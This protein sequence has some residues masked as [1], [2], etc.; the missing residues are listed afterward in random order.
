MKKDI[1]KS[2]AN[3]FK[4]SPMDTDIITVNHY[5][6][7]GVCVR[8]M[9]V[10]AGALVI[11]ASHKTKHLTTL[12]KGSM[13]IRLGNESKLVEAP[14][15]FESL[16]GSRKVGLAYT[17]CVVHNVF[18]TNSKD[19]EEIERQFTTMH[20]DKYELMLN[21]LGLSSSEVDKLSR[22]KST[23]TPMGQFVV[24]PSSIQGQGL[25]S[26]RDIPA[27]EFLGTASVKGMR[28]ELG[29]FVNHSNEPNLEFKVCGDTV[30]VYSKV[31]IEE[32]TE[33][34]VDYKNNILQFKELLCQQ[35]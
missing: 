33:F 24:G 6:S 35:Q 12:V 30:N 13:Q 31:S 1:S 11:G 26:D 21:D 19:V 7:E 34:T 9:I 18:P 15:T 16:A 3:L 10:P 20:E 2:L 5:F 23:Y 4:G 27:H 25:F 22:D 8:E 17:D 14:A 28:S 32:G 29:R